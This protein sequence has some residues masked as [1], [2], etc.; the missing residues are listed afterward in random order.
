MLSTGQCEIELDCLFYRL[1]DIT[2]IAQE[3]RSLENR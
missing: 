1:F 2:E 3:R